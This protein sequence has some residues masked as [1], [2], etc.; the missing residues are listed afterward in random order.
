MKL[1]NSCLERLDDDSLRL[2]I[3]KSHLAKPEKNCL[4]Q[5]FSQTVISLLESKPTAI[6]KKPI[7]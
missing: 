4:G 6:L 1:A 2:N 3:H 7:T 5:Q